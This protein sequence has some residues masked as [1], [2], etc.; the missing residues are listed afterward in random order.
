MAESVAFVCVCT[1]AVLGRVVTVSAIGCIAIAIGEGG[2]KRR[3]NDWGAWSREME[4]FQDLSQEFA[5]SAGFHCV[6]CQTL[7]VSFFVVLY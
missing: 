7:I 1:S 6:G 4:E 2:V 5:T 3:C